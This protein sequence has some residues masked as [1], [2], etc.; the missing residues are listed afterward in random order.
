MGLTN[1]QEKALELLYVG[2]KVTV[3]ISFGG[4]VLEKLMLLIIF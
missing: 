3:T 2:L 1:G 4:L